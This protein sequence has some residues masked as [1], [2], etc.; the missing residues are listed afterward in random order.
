VRRHWRFAVVLLVQAAIL[1]AMAGRHAAAR[2][3]GTAIT[4]RTAPVDPY[5]ILSGYHLVLTYEVENAPDALLPRGLARGDRLWLLVRRAEPA[6]E[7]EAV[8]RERPG[9]T[10]D[11]VALPARWDPW[12]RAAIEGADRVY[13][14]ETERSRAEKLFRDAGGRGLVD[15]RVG[16][17]GTIAV[18]RLRVGGASFGD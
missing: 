11:R 13:I 10:P 18:L 2:A 4:L 9:E 14:P 15:L 7:L 8:A 1:A 5:D 6:W 16:D 3:W 17:D 12:R